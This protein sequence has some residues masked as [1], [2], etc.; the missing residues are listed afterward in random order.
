MNADVR[1]GEALEVLRGL[2]AE[3]VDA[4][5]TSPPY[6][7][8]RDYGHPDQL[9]MEERVDDYLARLGAILDECRRVLTPAGTCWLNIGD[10][11]ARKGGGRAKGSD[12]GR[13]YLGTP[14]RAV[15]GL[16]AGELIGV[17]WMLAFELRR[18]GWLVRGEQVWSKANPIPE[19]SNVS[20]PHRSHE[21]V[22]LFA[23]SA[24]HYYDR[25]A[26]RT[27]LAPKTLETI[28]THRKVNGGD[29]VWVKA[30][31]VHDS[32]RVRQPAVTDDGECRGACLRSVWHLASE[33]FDGAH[34][35]VMPSRLA[36]V[37]VL[38]GCPEGGLVLDPF[39]GAGTTGVVAI[40]C[41]RRFLG[42]ELVP[43][44]AELARERIRA[45]APLFHQS[46]NAEGT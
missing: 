1:C 28:G 11:Y 37:C 35:A 14:G 46:S 32:M 45:D 12:M 8:M 31:R 9:G 17:P 42:I 40:R 23:K 3:T 39:A 20:R 2:E 30:R 38:S 15:E 4:V 26:A 44:Y 6:W 5:V 16:A 43:E 18:R 41:G 27:P 29:P 34:F 33:P 24:R 13:R 21:H 19:G 25:D 10:A 36:Q 22:F 7:R